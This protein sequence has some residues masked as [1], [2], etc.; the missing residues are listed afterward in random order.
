[1][2]EADS[3][4]SC[5]SGLDRSRARLEEFLRE[6][7]A[8]GFGLTIADFAR[9]QRVLMLLLV[10]GI[11]PDEEAAGAWLAPV[12]C[13]SRS[14]QE[15]FHRLF[16]ARFGATAGALFKKPGTNPTRGSEITSTTTDR[17]RPVRWI[18]MLASCVVG[19]VLLRTVI[20][21][22][23]G[24]SIAA[25]N[26]LNGFKEPNITIKDPLEDAAAL[27]AAVVAS[28]AAVP[29]ALTG[30]IVM[31][32]RTRQLGLIRKAGSAARRS[33]QMM[34]RAVSGN[35]FSSS[36]LGRRIAP[37]RKH[38][39]A[40]GKSLDVR[41]TLR[42]TLKSA[43][44]LCLRFGTR[45]RTPEY[46]LLVDVEGPRDHIAATGEALVTALRRESVVVTRYHYFGDPRRL[47]PEHSEGRPGG[48]LLVE[49]AAA[50]HPDHMVLVLAEARSFFDGRH[51]P[52]E[53][54]G[55]LLAW[56]RVVVLTPCPREW[57]GW[58][59]LSLQAHGILQVPATTGGLVYLAEC[60][61]LEMP[62]HSGPVSDS[63]AARLDIAE[64]L[65]D[66]RPWLLDDSQPPVEIVDELLSELAAWL[67][68]EPF[69]LLQAVAFFPRI[70]PSLTLFLGARLADTERDPLASE[71]TFGSL[72][73][74]PWLRAGMMP[75]W[76]RLAMIRRT[77]LSTRRR[78]LGIIQ[79]FL[80]RGV[81][82]TGAT[83]EIATTL[84]RY[85]L[86]RWIERDVNSDLQ[87]RIFVT[88][89]KE[90]DPNDLVTP[91][92]SDLVSQVRAALRLTDTWLLV[93]GASLATLIA[94]V[95]PV[96]VGVDFWAAAALIAVV[97]MA[98]SPLVVLPILM[99]MHWRK[100]S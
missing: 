67:G 66:N 2:A 75:D 15:L 49:D 31:R 61:R 34:L 87:D 37:L 90:K 80:R 7:E 51:E 97:L 27:R 43:G 92:A 44:R 23:P 46:V 39:A 60:L 45:P 14:E 21:Q 55:I 50:L 76:L 3:G 64:S 79:E 93:L 81:D 42:A 47:T 8:N 77:D 29:L 32:R 36:H 98:L 70:E 99:F 95:V 96:S 19:L 88:L 12:V 1:M 9:V 6:L 28:C 33:A 100:F 38:W 41:R 78:I 58:A 74:L 30:W 24:D 48:T 65:E 85:A 35:L 4:Q 16:A 54:L 73:R 53:W 10:H 52:Y 91:L 82:P 22:Q 59:E 83:L 5:L 25:P 89:L 68:R 17:E 94:L 40:P 69:H 62:H 57:W 11:R 18:L 86:A 84:D 72:S 20:L 56:G 63:R 71:R 26:S 13:G